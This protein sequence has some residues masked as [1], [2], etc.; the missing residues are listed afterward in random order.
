MSVIVAPRNCL[1]LINRF[2]ES[3]LPSPPFDMESPAI[4]TLWVFIWGVIRRKIIFLCDWSYI[5]W[6]AK[7]FFSASVFVPLAFFSDISQLF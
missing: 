7:W 5:T 6:G 1:A 2:W 4:G 3:K